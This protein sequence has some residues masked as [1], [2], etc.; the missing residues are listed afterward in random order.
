MHCPVVSN[1]NFIHALVTC[2][3]L[4]PPTI[5]QT[6][7]PTLRLGDP[8]PQSVGRPGSDPTGGANKKQNSLGIRSRT[9]PQV[10]YDMDPDNGTIMSVSNTSPEEVRLEA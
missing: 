9:K 8:E 5:H 6:H 2:H 4:E 10:R 7:S 1:K 3:G